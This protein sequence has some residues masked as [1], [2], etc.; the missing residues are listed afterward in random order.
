MTDTDRITSYENILFTVVVTD[1]DG[2]DD[3]I[4]GTLTSP[5]G[6][7]FGAFA[8]AAQEGAYTASVSWSQF[9][10]MQPIEFIS[11]LTRKVIATFYDVSGNSVQVEYDVSFHC[12]GLG[13]CDGEC[14][15]LSQDDSH[16]G[17]CNRTCE[18]DEIR[19][20]YA[21]CNNGLCTH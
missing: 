1:P 18:Y 16:C 2:I 13:A 17:E 3:L 9:Q 15:N 5:D 7:A 10:R 6:K 21:Y 8:T 19:G 20:T 4:G 12:D 14:T 11:S